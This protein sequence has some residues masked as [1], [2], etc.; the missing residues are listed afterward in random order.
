MNLNISP[1]V[2]NSETKQVYSIVYIILYIKDDWIDLKL[3]EFE[4][5]SETILS[6]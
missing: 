6:I 5:P 4:V 2:K 3:S 1:C